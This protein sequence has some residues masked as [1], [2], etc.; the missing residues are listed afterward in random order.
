MSIT[1]VARG[2]DAFRAL[3]SAVRSMAEQFGGEVI[4]VSK[5]KA[6]RIR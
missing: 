6:Y 2:S 1:N 5:G 4:V 3:D